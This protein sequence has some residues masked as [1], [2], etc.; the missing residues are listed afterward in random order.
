LIDWLSE[1]TVLVLF[2]ELYTPYLYIYL[3]LEQFQWP[4]NNWVELFWRRTYWFR[5]KTNKSTWSAN[6]L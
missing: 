2:K 6:V 3:D 5:N 4:G 1:K